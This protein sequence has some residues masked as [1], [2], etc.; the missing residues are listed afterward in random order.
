MIGSRAVVSPTQKVRGAW[1]EQIKSHGPHVCGE[2]TYMVEYD[3]RGEVV[4]GR[5]NYS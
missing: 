5:K 2:E 4:D 1:S 3:S